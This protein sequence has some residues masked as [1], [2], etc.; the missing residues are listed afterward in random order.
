MVEITRSRDVIKYNEMNT[1]TLNDEIEKKKKI[2]SCKFTRK[3]MESMFFS[4][5]CLEYVGYG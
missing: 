4:S 5:K 3:T 1:L 2:N